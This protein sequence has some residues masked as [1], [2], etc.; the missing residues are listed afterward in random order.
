MTCLWED[1][2]DYVS[3]LSQFNESQ[4]YTYLENYG[5][6][7]IIFS[8]N[9]EFSDRENYS[10]YRICGNLWYN[11][12]LIEKV[13]FPFKKMYSRYNVT[14]FLLN[15]LRNNID[16]DQ[17]YCSL[18]KE[19]VFACCNLAAGPDDIKEILLKEGIAE[20][21]IKLIDIDTKNYV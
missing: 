21:I 3:H 1:S 2:L 16:I 12:K 6:L 4:T 13:K 5:L 7:Q 17:A 10:I 8:N 9:I 11:N 14:Y 18:E 20:K 19:F 15:Q